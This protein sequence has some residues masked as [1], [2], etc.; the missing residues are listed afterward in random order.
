M[1]LWPDRKSTLFYEQSAVIPYRQIDGELEVLLITTRSNKRWIIPKGLVE[2]GL[3][4]A[5]SAAKEALEEAGVAGTVGQKIIGEYAYKKW[6]GT[7]HVQVYSLAVTEVHEQWEEQAFR[8]RQWLPLRQA[9][10]AVKSNELRQILLLL[11]AT[12]SSNSR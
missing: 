3:S 8:S 1:N 6:R 12:L 7:C 5:A 2:P 9:A 10:A 11:P 4:P